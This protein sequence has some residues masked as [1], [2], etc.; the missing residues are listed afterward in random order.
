MSHITIRHFP[1]DAL[2]QLAAQVLERDG[3]SAQ[4]VGQY[5]GITELYSVSPGFVEV[6]VDESQATAA[7]HILT[8]N[9]L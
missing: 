9:G 5:L 1:N 7:D 3:I 4:V 8:A 6:L 2:A